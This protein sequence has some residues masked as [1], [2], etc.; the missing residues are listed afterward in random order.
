LSREL[1]DPAIERGEM[2]LAADYAIPLPM[3]V[4][5]EMLGIPAADWPQ[6][7]RWSDVHLL[8]SYTIPGLTTEQEIGAAMKEYVPAVEEMQGYLG[9][10]IEQR[11]GARKDDLLTRLIE[12]ELDGARLTPDEIFAFF[13]ILL[14]GGQETTANLIG[15]AILSFL[16]HPGALARLRSA[17]GLL[18]TAIEEVLRYRSPL[19]WVFRATRRKLAMHGQVI[20]A[21]KIVIIMI[22]SANRDPQQ[23]PEPDRFDISRD[24]NP[25]VAFGQ[26]IHACLGAPLAR[27]EARIAFSDLLERL[28][29]LAP[30][31][32]EPWGTAEGAFRPWSLS[33]VDPLQTVQW[34]SRARPPGQP[35]ESC[36][37]KP[38]HGL[39]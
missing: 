1:L 20:P 28:Q 22:G 23:F 38:R 25:H 16:E 11:K 12:A 24:P 14:V 34:G 5:A 27:L 13:Q 39:A 9:E 18:P 17:P 35:P 21:G 33:S 10:L 19:Q 26:G 30:A 37:P 6:F 31:S 2:D 3:K 29:D 4:I 7:K 32:P 8:L 15:N 36:A